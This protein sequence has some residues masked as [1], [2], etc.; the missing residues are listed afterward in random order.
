VD[1][2]VAIFN[3]DTLVRRLLGLLYNDGKDW[4][5]NVLLYQLTGRDA[6]KLE[7][8]KRNAWEKEYKKTDLDY[9]EAYRRR[10]N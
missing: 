10:L 8:M 6:L 3:K 4:Y 7:G 2:A 9:W 1:S 5:A